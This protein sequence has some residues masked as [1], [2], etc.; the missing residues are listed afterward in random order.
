MARPVTAARS[1][2]HEVA[3][4]RYHPDQLQVLLN[5]S[6]LLVSLQGFSESPLLACE[7]PLRDQFPRKSV[8]PNYSAVLDHFLQPSGRCS[9]TL[10]SPFQTALHSFQLL[11]LWVRGTWLRCVDDLT[12][13]WIPLRPYSTDQMARKEHHLILEN[14]VRYDQSK[15]TL[16]TT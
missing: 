12:P 16:R 14:R 2:P 8:Q 11:D 5:A 10:T 6:S 13:A 4:L 1:K 7:W 9:H 3:N 15:P